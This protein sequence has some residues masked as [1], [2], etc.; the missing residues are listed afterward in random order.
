[1]ARSR[2][3][4]LTDDEKEQFLPLC[5]DFV[6]ELRSRSDALSTLREKTEEWVAQG[7]RL[8]WLIDPTRQVVE[9]H[10]PGA[11]VESLAGPESLSGEPVLAGFVVH[12]VP[13][14]ETGL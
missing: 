4:T 3:A 8:G 1:V 10:R 9:V 7:V 14:W 13:L 5:P 12:L 6:V 2:L 11:P